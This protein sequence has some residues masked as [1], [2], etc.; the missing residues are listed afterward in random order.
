[1]TDTDLIQDIDESLEQ[2]DDELEDDLPELLGRME[3]QT[4]DLVREHPE[5]FGRVVARMETMDIASFV[6]ENPETAD[7]FQELL[8]AGMNVLVESSPE[9]KESIDDDITVT[10]EADDCPMAGHLEVDGTEQT[11]TGGA[12]TL[13]DPMLEITGPAD[14]LVGLIVGRVD[15]IQGFMQQQYQM[16]GPVH[17]GTR[18][19]PI[20]NSLSDQVPA[21][22][23]S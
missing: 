7:Q 10:F 3:G 5:T 9:V 11:M 22:A 12:G 2:S 1:M 21:S 15:P 13:D 14:T 6:S 17:K 20:M 16:D 8:W 19:A 23:E 4:E 18:L